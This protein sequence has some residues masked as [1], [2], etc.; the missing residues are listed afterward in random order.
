MK[1]TREK[2]EECQAYLTIE[3]E[4]AEMGAALT[5]AYQHLAG[6]VKIPGFRQGKAP[7][8]VV[9][10][11]VGKERVTEEMLEHLVPEAYQ[12][13]LQEQDLQP[14]AQP[15]IEVV[16]TEPTVTFKAVVPLR[17]EVTLGDYH[18]IKAAPEEVN[19][20]KEEVNGVI[21]QLRHQHATWETVDR[22]AGFGDLIVMDVES[23]VDGEAFVNQ[24]GAQYLVS[25]NAAAPLKGFPEELVGIKKGQEK[26]FTLSVPEDYRKKEWVG[27]EAS[28]KVKINEIKAEKLPEVDDKFA[29]QVNPEFDDVKTL[30]K[31]VGDS[32][33][34]RAEARVKQEFENNA[35]DAAVEQAEVEYPPILVEV[36][37][38]Q[39]I[40]DQAR[41]LQMDQKAL[42][43]Y[44]RNA[45]KT[46]EQLREEVRP[47]AVK[48]VSSSLVLGKIAEEEKIEVSEAEIDAEIARMLQNTQAEDEAK[49]KEVF[50]QE[51]SRDSI[52]Q[53]LLTRKTVERLAE[54][55]HKNHQ[56]KGSKKEAK[57]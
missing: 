34:E 16:Q 43:Q 28:F 41:R 9:A 47:T 1:V 10:R 32:M 17:P 20:T 44:L 36:E 38:N 8:S 21:E 40:E 11:F 33:K 25:E 18:Q 24:H 7:G 13:A 49:L 4:D 19:I 2:T 29:K 53:V 27:K 52:R 6:E 14:V 35:I 55:A 15:E 57:E 12:K 22:V 45:N 31:Q 48:R 5:E 46:P 30:R 54:I 23:S 26:D 42:E 3:M 37:I 56:S 39:I 50:H 51:E